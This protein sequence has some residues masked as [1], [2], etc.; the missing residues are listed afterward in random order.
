VTEESL[1]TNVNKTVREALHG[2]SSQQ[3]LL[4]WHSVILRLVVCCEK[5]DC[6]GKIY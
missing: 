6:K 3:E 2:R 4:Y 5:M 1:T